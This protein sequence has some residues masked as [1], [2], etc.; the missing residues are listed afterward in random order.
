[1]GL[2]AV[3]R[4][5]FGFDE[6]LLDDRVAGRRRFSRQTQFDVAKRCGTDEKRD[7]S[8]VLRWND[9]RFLAEDGVTW[10]K[11]PLIIHELIIVV[12]LLL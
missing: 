5:T 6:Q 12:Q 2:I 10:M 11:L 3:D 7:G 4:F 8:A 9:N 1:M